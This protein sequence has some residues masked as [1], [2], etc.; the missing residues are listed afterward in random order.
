VQNNYTNQ[1]LENKCKSV[2]DTLEFKLNKNIVGAPLGQGPNGPACA[3]D[4]VYLL[5]VKNLNLWML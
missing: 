1:L 5:N 4:Y 2:W 3:I